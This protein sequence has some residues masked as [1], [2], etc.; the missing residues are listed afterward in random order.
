MNLFVF[1]FL[2]SVFYILYDDERCKINFPVRDNKVFCIVLY[3]IVLYCIVLYC[4]VLYC[5]V[6]YCIVLC[7]IVLYCIVLYCIVL[8][9]GY[10]H[11]PAGTFHQTIKHPL[12]Q[13]RRKFQ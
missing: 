13:L 12:R 11:E 5:I 3:C 4:I 7:C 8:K 10:L 9:W 1:L 6:L 2:Y